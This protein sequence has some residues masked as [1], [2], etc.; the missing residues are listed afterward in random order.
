ML[1]AV[2][3][4]IFKCKFP[5]TSAEQY[6]SLTALIAYWGGPFQRLT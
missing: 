3:N 6:L 4:R 5:F 1:L 2:R